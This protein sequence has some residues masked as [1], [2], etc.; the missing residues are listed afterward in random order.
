MNYCP[1]CGQKLTSDYENCP[2]C[3]YQLPQKKKRRASETKSQT[4]ASVTASKGQQLANFLRCLRVKWPLTLAAIVLVILTYFYIGKL[5]SVIV[6]ISLAIWGFLATNAAP[7]PARLWRKKRATPP[8]D[9]QPEPR[10]KPTPDSSANQPSTTAQPIEDGDPVMTRRRRSEVPL[11]DPITSDL[12]MHPRFRLSWVILALAIL[13]LSTTYW[14]SFFGNNTL[15]IANLNLNTT[16]SLAAVCQQGIILLGNWLN[17][18]L[19]THLGA[20]ILAIGPLI[21]IIGSLIPKNWG[22]RLTTKGAQ[23]TLAFYILGLIALKV[24]LGI[25]ANYGWTTNLQLGLGGY[26]ALIGSLAMF[27]LSEYELHKHWPGH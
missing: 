27:I 1:N 7:V 3:G 25:G 13:T 9:P 2:Y 6:A 5:I 14:P 19:N 24:G 15:Q 20:W 17:F 10:S 11:R 4:A 21:V 23:W 12:G 18:P 16:P 22:R 8:V 26:V